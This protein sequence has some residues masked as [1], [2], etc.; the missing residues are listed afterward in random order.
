MIVHTVSSR[1]QSGP[2]EI[3]VLLPD[4]YAPGHR[5]PVLYVLPVEPEGEHVYGDGLSVLRELDVANRHGCILVQMGFSHTPWY[6]DHATEPGV[7]PASHLEQVVVPFVEDHYATIQGK[8]GRLL[9]G[10]SKSGW[11]AFSLILH[12]P[13]FW[14]YAAAWDAPW[15]M[16]TFHWDVSEAFGT[17]AQFD[18]HRPD[19]LVESRSEPFRAATRLVLGGEKDWGPVR[20][21]PPGAS[22]TQGFHELLQQH[23]IRHVYRNDLCVKH[24]WNR[25][26][27]GPMVDELM[28]LA[29]PAQMKTD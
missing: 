27:V 18:N 29:R 2:R 28:T 4:D 24:T 23:S 11:G 6:A 10:F 7:R 17:V 22:H 3:R 21:G 12:K 14:G 9:I 1:F 20:E 5:Y 26:W 25:G 15:L 13:D 16:P 8:E 19:R